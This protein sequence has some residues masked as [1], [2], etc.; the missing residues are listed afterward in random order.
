MALGPV[1]ASHTLN[2][3]QVLT[4]FHTGVNWDMCF[5]AQGSLPE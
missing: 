4:A 1:S 2:P 3:S 5:A